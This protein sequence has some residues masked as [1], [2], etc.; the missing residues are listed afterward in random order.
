MDGNVSDI[1]NA[2]PNTE[3]HIINDKKALENIAAIVFISLLMIVGIPGNITALLVYLR[4]FKPSTYRT[5]VVCLAVL[6]LAAC[7][8]SMPFILALLRYPVLFLHDEVCKLFRL[9]SYIPCVSSVFI[10]IT[11]AVER[12]RKICAPHGTQMS[13]RMAKHICIMDI[14]IACCLSSPAAVIYGKRSLEIEI[15]NINGSSCS[16]SDDMVNTK[17]PEYFNFANGFVLTASI[18][19]L[20]I[21]YSLIGKKIVC[22]RKTGLGTNQLQSGQ[23]YTVSTLTTGI[24]NIQVEVNKREEYLDRGKTEFIPVEL[25]TITKYNKRHAKTIRTTRVIFTVTAVFVCSFLP[26]LAFSIIA[27]L[28]FEKVLLQNISFAGTVT[29]KLFKHIFF[30]SNATNPIIYG[31]CDRKFMDEICR[32]YKNICGLFLSRK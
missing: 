7:C 20:S 30:I 3:L 23:S 2:D 15:D 1:Q 21:I 22:M 19:A 17:Y 4:K 8:I 9:L 5:F 31:F 32:L 24:D 16:V 26:Y 6:D 11:I 13:D 10:L 14:L 12:Y 18:I 27:A 25:D 28:G 29:Y